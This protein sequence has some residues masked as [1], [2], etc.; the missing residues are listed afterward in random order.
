M[1]IIFYLFQI[2]NYNNNFKLFGV[3]YFKKIK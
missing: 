1:E 3:I 2:L